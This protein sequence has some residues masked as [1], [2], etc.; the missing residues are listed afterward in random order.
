MRDELF[1]ANW[2]PVL[3]WHHFEEL[4]RHANEEVAE[5]RVKFL[6]TLPLV[7][8]V[9]RADCRTE[10]IGSVVDLHAT[11]IKIFLSC[12]QCNTSTNEFIQSTRAQLL[13]FGKPS[14]ITMLT[15]WRELRPYLMDMG[16]KQQEIASICHTTIDT[17]ANVPLS[18]LNNKAA[19]SWELAKQFY[20]DEVSSINNE[21]V[22]R[23]D[24]R[25]LNPD[26][27]AAWFCDVVF[28]NIAAIAGSHR[29]PAEAFV[30]HFGF[31]IGDF[32]RDLNLGEFK[33]AVRRRKQ[34]EVSVAQLGLRIEDVWPK[35]RDRLMPSEEIISQI[36]KSRKNAARSSG[37]DLNDDYHATLIPY[38]DAVVVDKRTHEN[39][40][41]A[42]R[43]NPEL[44]LLLKPVLKAAY[45]HLI[46][47][48]LRN[49]KNF[50]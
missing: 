19:M 10:I 38:L 42:K 40:R 32:H 12:E 3:Y 18:A 21:L 30:E 16:I 23:G 37:S 1:V 2:I 13:K 28:S 26:D 43:R 41:Q 44:S 4:L 11:E 49:N 27:L 6:L 5:N 36:R 9:S 24:K 25:L 35:L 31:S 50:A 47:S 7:A 29:P 33:E 34:L 48:I 45:Y 46:P 22:R 20:S 8:W 14:E 39:L 17:Y 15:M